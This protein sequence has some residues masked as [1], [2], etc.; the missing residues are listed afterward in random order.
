MFQTAFKLLMFDFTLTETGMKDYKKVLAII[1]EYIRKVREEWLSAGIPLFEEMSTISKL[2][3]DI[4]HPSESEAVT[5]LLSDAMIF[6][7]D[8][9]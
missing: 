5:S 7:N 1:F 9:T 8:K 6:A 2:D 3:Y 4:Y